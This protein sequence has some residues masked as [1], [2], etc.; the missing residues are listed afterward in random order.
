MTF[1]Q[2]AQPLALLLISLDALT[3]GVLALVWLDPR[4]CPDVSLSRLRPSLRATI[5]LAFCAILLGLAGAAIL[6]GLDAHQQGRYIAP[7]TMTP[8]A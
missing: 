3:L 6:T 1:W 7:T 4:E 8:A 2:F 5:A